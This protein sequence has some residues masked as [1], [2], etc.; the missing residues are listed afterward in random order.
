MGRSWQLR[1]IYLHGFASSPASSKAQFFSRKFQEA[2]YDVSVP[3]LDGGDFRNL[4]ITSQL[5]I[6]EREARGQR[7]ILM[8]SSLGGYL[9]AVFAARH[10]AQVVR[11]VMMAP[12]FCFA[13][14]WSEELPAMA[15]WKRTGVM[16]LFHYG[17]RR[18]R[19]IGYNLIADALEYDDYPVVTQPTLVLH[20]SL[21]TVVP[22][23][24]SEEF[25]KRQS[26]TARLCVYP[27]SGH[28][29]TDVVN[30]MW[31]EISSFLK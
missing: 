11:A 22:V 29:L 23:A 24:L 4:T 21:D 31:T 13:S 9:T 12:A 14:R 30:E 25:V 17:Q 15:E 5:D 28:E 19:E 27:K 2:G 7:V 1:V 3:A 16:K 18:T 20:G 6:L 26:A 10:A 8:G